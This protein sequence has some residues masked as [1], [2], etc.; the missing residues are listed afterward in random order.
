MNDPYDLERFLAAQD[1]G[2]TYAQAV[3]E[4][5]GGTK[6]SHWMWFI[7][8]Q[9]AGLGQS[10]TS[11]KYAIASLDEAQTYLRHP[12]LGARLIEC[13]EAVAG[14]KGR[15]AA[16]IFGGIDSRKLHSSLTLFSRAAPEEAIFQQILDQYFEGL[17]DP[18]TD[19]ILAAQQR[20]S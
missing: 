7:F 9:I 1:T 18:A 13:A 10:A 19:E 16:Q 12:V 2:G 5:R 8:P 17:P 6:R 15:T 14:H 11:R 4:L 3:A 20:T